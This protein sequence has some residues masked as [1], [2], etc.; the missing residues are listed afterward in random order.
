MEKIQESLVHGGQRNDIIVG[1]LDVDKLKEE[2]GLE[3]LFKEIDIFK[4]FTLVIETSVYFE[5]LVGELQKAKPTPV[6]NVN[7]RSYLKKHITICSNLSKYIKKK[8]KI[9]YQNKIPFMFELHT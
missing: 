8:H 7:N 2:K 5:K 3:K 9:Q 1:D 4:K 6:K